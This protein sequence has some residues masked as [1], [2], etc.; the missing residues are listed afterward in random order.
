MPRRHTTLKYR[1]FP[2]ACISCN[3]LRQK[4]DVKPE[5]LLTTPLLGTSIET[6]PHSIDVVV[7]R[8]VEHHRAFVSRG[9]R[10][11]EGVPTSAHYENVFYLFTPPD[12]WR[13]RG[14]ETIGH[15]DIVYNFLTDSAESR[16]RFLERH[17]LSGPLILEASGAE[18]AKFYQADPGYHIHILVKVSVFTCVMHPKVR[19]RKP[20]RCQICSM[21][22]LETVDE[23]AYE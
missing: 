11:N 1:T 13:S 14:E 23:T 21:D 2:I 4:I 19:A 17:S 7:N 12:L 10:N 8:P 18:P 16:D 5:D 6:K 3:R 20:G 9:A 22:L 15:G